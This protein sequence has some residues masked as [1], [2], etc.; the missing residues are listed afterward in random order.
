MPRVATRHAHQLAFRQRFSVGV[1]MLGCLL[2]IA[3][4]IVL[5]ATI[6]KTRGPS[7]SGTPWLTVSIGF[8]LAGCGVVLLYGERGKLIDR[9]QR[10]VARWWGIVRPLWYRTRD[11]QP[12]RAVVVESCG[13]QSAARWHVSLFA[14]QNQPLR[15]FELASHEAAQAAARQIATFL[16][17]TILLPAA[18]VADAPPDKKVAPPASDRWSYWRPHRRALRF[19]GAVLLLVAGAL[20]LGSAGSVVSQDG[21]WWIWLAVAAP[22]FASGAWLLW[23]GRKVEIDRR[24]ARVW[25][26]WPLPAAIYDLQAFFAVI[27]A[28]VEAGEGEP[29]TC[30]VGL[31]GAEQLRLELVA[32]MSAD[33]AR[34]AAARL[35]V[36]TNLPLIDESESAVPSA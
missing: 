6:L 23:G 3:G 18:A 22:L 11:L 31:I 4:G 30:L 14:D 12:Y 21:R 19:L 20:L 26:T 17:L 10:T 7:L 29:K 9:E 28:T 16:S 15:L 2:L 35:A 36:T 8:V 25:R 32:T 24:S 27:V 34:E 5:V 1:R 13:D 33:E